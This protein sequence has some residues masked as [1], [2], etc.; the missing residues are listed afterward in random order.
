MCLIDLISGKN[1]K[2]TPITGHTIFY[3]HHHMPLN[4]SYAP[5][6]FKWFSCKIFHLEI[7]NLISYVV[8]RFC[9]SHARRQTVRCGSK[10]TSHNPGSAETKLV[11]KKI[12]LY[13]HTLQS[14]E[15]STETSPIQEKSTIT[16]GYVTLRF[17]TRSAWGSIG[18][19]RKGLERLGRKGLIKEAENVACQ[20]HY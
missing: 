7:A 16:P 15:L 13:K 5:T 18:S 2:W 12:Q 19:L 17:S 9:N 1:H 3:H 4:N 14:V 20:K 10:R 8:S 6:C 11:N